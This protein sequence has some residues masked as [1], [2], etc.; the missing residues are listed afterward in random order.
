MQTL[1]SIKN[2][3]EAK[4]IKAIIEELQ[5]ENQRELLILSI[6]EMLTT[7]KYESSGRN[8]LK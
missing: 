2:E 1:Y 6:M 7:S 5:A 3:R 8:A 4:I